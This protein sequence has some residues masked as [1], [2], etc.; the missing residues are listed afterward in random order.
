[1]PVVN[2]SAIVPFTAEQMFRLVDDVPSYPQFLPWCSAARM[3]SAGERESTGELEV[4]RIGVRQTF[5]THNRLYPFERID[6]KLREGPF[7]RLNGSWRFTPLGEAA[8][9]VEL[10]LEFEFSGKLINAAF[11]KV[12]GHIADTMVGAFCK[13]AKEVYRGK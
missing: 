4:S 7:R 3:I 8:C 6:L 9:K 13:R 2:K 10:A 5:S 1:M 11:G 12:F